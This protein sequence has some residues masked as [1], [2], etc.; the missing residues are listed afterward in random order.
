[1]RGEGRFHVAGFRFQVG[2]QEWRGLTR[3]RGARGG[4]GS[5]GAWPSHIPIAIGV[6][7]RAGIPEIFSEGGA[8]RGKAEL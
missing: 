1:M 3:R 4:P 5:A 7:K 8:G 6:K 2:A